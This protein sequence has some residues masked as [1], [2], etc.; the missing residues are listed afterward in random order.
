MT[1]SKHSSFEFFIDPGVD[2]FFIK[3]FGVFNLE[4]L[5]EGFKAL[6]SHKDYRWDLNRLVDI[7]NCTLDLSSD[8]IRTLSEKISSGE[9]SDGSFRRAF[10]VDNSLIHGLV[11]IFESL[12]SNPSND[13]QIFYLQTENI[14]EEI[15]LWL[16]LDKAHSFPKFQNYLNP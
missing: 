8:E 11:R 2:C 3:Y 12:N 9:K 14:G 5:L 4:I 15:R 7:T 10:F 16:S 13:Y 1:I 6:E